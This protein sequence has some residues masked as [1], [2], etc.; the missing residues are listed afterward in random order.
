MYMEIH[1][2]ILILTGCDLNIKII[3]L[4]GITLGLASFCLSHLSQE[5][6]WK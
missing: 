2:K 6:I 4:V 3:S 5:K 1:I